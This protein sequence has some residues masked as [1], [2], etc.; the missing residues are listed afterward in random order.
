MGAMEGQSETSNISSSPNMNSAE[1][2]QSA[3]IISTLEEPGPPPDGG[4]P[5]YLQVL[6]AHL[7]CFNI[8]GFVIS[9]GVLQTYYLSILSQTSSDLSWI[10]S[11]QVFVIFFVG[12]FSGRAIDAG[13][14]RL[15]RDAMEHSF[16]CFEWPGLVSELYSQIPLYREKIWTLSLASLEY[17]VF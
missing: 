1:K 7:V 14:F 12:A 15:V 6:M 13:H 8:W 17:H 16:L 4:L 11:T 2:Q 9:F 3:S 5:A 10:G